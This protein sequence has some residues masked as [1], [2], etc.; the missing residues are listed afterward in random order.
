MKKL[1]S[2]VLMFATIGAAASCKN[3]R[4]NAPEVSEPLTSI[5]SEKSIFRNYDDILKRYQVLLVSK[6]KEKNV[7]TDP[8]YADPNDCTIEGALQSTVINSDTDMMG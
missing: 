4:S 3:Q 6:G 1:L 7:Q 8:L 2:V 5:A